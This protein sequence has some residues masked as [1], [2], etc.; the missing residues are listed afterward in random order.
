MA[1]IDER[2]GKDGKPKYRVRVRV[3]GQL[4]TL[5]FARKT[6]AKDWAARTESDLKE[7]KIKAQKMRGR[8]NVATLI[9]RYIRDEAPKY[10]PHE[11]KRKTRYLT[12]WKNE[13]GHVPVLD[14][15]SSDIAAC[16]D[17]LLKTVSRLGEPMKPATVRISMVTLSHM[18]NIAAREWEWV[19][20]NP[21]ERVSK[22]KV[23]NNRCRY[24][25]VEEMARLIPAVRASKC[26]YLPIIINMALLTGGRREE[27]SG[28]KW[29]DVDLQRGRAI[30]YDTKNG[31]N[32]S[33][34][35]Q[36]SLVEDLK[37]LKANATPDVQYVFARED[38]R[39]SMVFEKHWQEALSQAKIEDFVFHDL[40]H[41]FASYLA[42]N[43]ATLMEI[44]QALGHQTLQMVKRYAHLTE[45]FQD[46]RVHSM[47][48][49]LLRDV[50]EQM[51]K[52]ADGK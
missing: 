36:P 4:R 34:F 5:T 47:G 42:M 46:K 23:D 12:W 18:F 28:L 9:D 15:G 33:T 20:D 21:V 31:T 29:S 48:V 35:L 49:E 17:K 1:V 50:E 11:Q 26:R 27:I 38:G 10:E 24:L 14:L 51:R 19:T 2:K 37:H 32:R 44:A 3:R 52:A 22:P 41:T 16:R 25:S 6:D 8:R 7:G 13:I 40:R 45:Q 30:F 39:K 43:G